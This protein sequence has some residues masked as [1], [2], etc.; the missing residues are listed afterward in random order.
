M[1]IDSHHLLLK[2]SG[3]IL[4]VIVQ[5]CNFLYGKSLRLL[6]LGQR[7]HAILMDIAKLVSV[8]PANITVKRALFP[9]RYTNTVCCYIFGLFPI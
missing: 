5:V 6:L 9:H 8:L 7:L 4:H 3:I 2:S 1:W